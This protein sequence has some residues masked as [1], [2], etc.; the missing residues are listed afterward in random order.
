MKFDFDTITNFDEHIDLSIPDYSHMVEHIVNFSSYFI[1]NNS[2]YYDIGC[3]TG[4][5]IDKIKKK[6]KDI[7]FNSIGIDKSSNLAGINSN[8]IVCDV[9]DFEYASFNFATIIF[10]LQF[11]DYDSKSRLL[12][13][14]YNAMNRQGSLI[15]CEKFYMPDGFF[16]DLF[17][18]AYYDYKLKS[19][20]EKEIMEK[21]FD[22][23]YIM[24]PSSD[25]E[26]I[27]LFMEAGFSKIEPF[28]Q[29]LQFKGWVLM[30]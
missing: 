25:N 14:L 9:N 4:I 20:S 17:T 1:K 18:F 15:I 28:W 19:F 12:T 23:R 10:T 21:Q 26:N 27:H 6:N 30:K 7:I 8:I 29:S 16:Q 13:T 22:L 5:L 2:T 11:L 24:R 3:S